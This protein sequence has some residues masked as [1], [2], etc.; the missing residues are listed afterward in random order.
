MYEL[1]SGQ[2]QLCAKRCCAA[3]TCSKLRVR[4]MSSMGVSCCQTMSNGTPLVR[5]SLGN[6]PEPKDFIADIRHK[7][8]A[9]AASLLAC[10]ASPSVSK[11]FCVG[12]QSNAI[13]TRVDRSQRDLHRSEAKSRRSAIFSA[14]VEKGTYI[15]L[16]LVT[17]ELIKHSEA[18]AW[19]SLGSLS[20][21]MYSLKTP[22]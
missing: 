13:S 9:V 16:R 17:L 22:G 5:D 11:G 3:A 1:P 14:M 19:S 21:P 20:V 15:K 6:Y 2:L 4:I 10:G 12:T 7:E 18:V 8:R